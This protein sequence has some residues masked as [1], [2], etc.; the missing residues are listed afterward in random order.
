MYVYTYVHITMRST[1]ICIHIRTY[2]CDSSVHATPLLPFHYFCQ[3]LEVCHLIIH[4]HVSTGQHVVTK[5]ETSHVVVRERAL[6]GQ[7]AEQFVHAQ[8]ELLLRGFTHNLKQLLLVFLVNESVREDP[9]HLVDPEANEFI[10]LGQV[11]LG[12]QQSAKHH[13]GEVSQVEHIVGLGWCGQE[14]VNTLFIHIQ[15]C[16]DYHLEGNE[17]RARERKS[18]GGRGDSEGEAGEG[19]GEKGG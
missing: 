5:E 13:S 15:G 11:S 1:Y 7:V 18:E 3:C 9:V 16:H 17:S 19:C 8:L 2:V 12:H 10:S 6:G 14:L 4:L